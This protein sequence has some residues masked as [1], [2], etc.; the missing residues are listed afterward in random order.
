M[1]IGD[2]VDL[3]DLTFNVLNFTF[4]VD[5]EVFYD[6]LDLNIRDL[7]WKYTGILMDG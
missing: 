3:V 1:I 6:N 2:L 7:Y 5:A 4:M